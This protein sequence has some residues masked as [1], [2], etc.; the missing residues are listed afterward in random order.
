MHTLL[1]VS[2]TRPEIIN[3][4]PPCHALRETGWANRILTCFDVLADITLKRAG[5]R[6]L[7]FSN[8]FRQQLEAV[9]AGRGWALMMALTESGGPQK[10][11]PRLTYRCWSCVKQPG[12]PRRLKPAAPW[13]LA[14]PTPIRPSVPA[15]SLWKMVLSYTKR[16]GRM[17]L[18]W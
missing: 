8:G 3:L 4:A 12:N 13:S 15:T 18:A 1:M 17:R 14:R 9:I 16:F 5:S 7:E 10:K 6:L 11:H 2:G